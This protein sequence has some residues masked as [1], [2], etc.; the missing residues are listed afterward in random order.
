MTSKN[1]RG[2]LSPSGVEKAATNAINKTSKTVLK[3]HCVM[4][5]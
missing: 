5:I 1:E 4:D 2:E 3:L